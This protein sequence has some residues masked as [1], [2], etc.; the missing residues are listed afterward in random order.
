L[1]EGMLLGHVVTCRCHDARFDVR[2]GKVLSAPALNDLPAYPVRIEAGDVLVGPAQKPKFPTPEGADPRTF[3]IVGGGAAGNSAAETLRREGFAGRIVM[4]TAEPDLPYDRPNLSKEFMSGEAKPEWMPLRSA[5]FYANQ[6]IEVLTSTRVTAVDPRS[7]TVSLSTG[8]TMSYDK[9]LLATGAIPR[10]L[11]VPGADGEACYQLR[12]FADGRL[13]VEAAASAKRAAL[14][15]AGFISMELASSLR[16]RGLEVTVISPEA[17]PFAK[18]VGEEV[19]AALRKRHEKDGVSFVLGAAVTDISGAKGSKT[20]TLSDGRRVSADFVVSGIGVRP[21]VEYLLGT[22]IAE[23]GAVPVS[24]Q[25]R[26]K[27]PDLFAAGDIALVPDRVS[28]TGIRIEHWVV[29]E[30]QG[31]HAARAMLGSDAPYDEVPFFW[32]RQTGVSLR[33]VGF[34]QT[35][36]EVVYRG[37]VDEGKFLVG[38][39]RDGMLKAASAIGL[40]NDLTAVKIIM[41]KKKPLPQAKLADGSVNLVDLARS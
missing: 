13:I 27:Y 39:Y 33:Y 10:K 1:N 7:K 17:V 5:K 35:W 21:A 11:P 26:T 12:S 25:L 8:Q 31:Q 36:D 28:G 3:L 23:N 41:G 34:T 22:D 32:T 20:I 15:G 30:R 16:K 18:V 24:P 2:S 9:A 19:A 14:I 6:K 37:N 40:A 29:A 38:Y 4:I